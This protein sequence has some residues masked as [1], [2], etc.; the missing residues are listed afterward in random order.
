[1]IFFLKIEKITF[2]KI[3]SLEYQ[4]TWTNEAWNIPLNDTVEWEGVDGDL[5]IDGTDN[6]NIKIISKF[7]GSL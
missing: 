3:L 2:L 5:N 1:M 7:L 4:R 6:D